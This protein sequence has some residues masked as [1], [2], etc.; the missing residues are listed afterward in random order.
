MNEA[1]KIIQL[2]DNLIE[3]NSLGQFYLNPEIAKQELWEGLKSGKHFSGLVLSCDAA[4]N[5]KVDINGIT[6]IM[7][8]N[9]VSIADDEEGLVHKALCQRKVGSTIKARVLKIEDDKIYVSRKLLIKGVRQ[10]YNNTITIGRIV[11][12]KVINIDENVGVFVDIGG[13]YVGII[14]KA[15]LENLFVTRLSDHVSINE[16]VEA[17]VIDVQ[18]NGSGDIAHLSLDRKSILPDFNS[19]AAEYNRGDVY[20]VKVKSV[21]QNGIYASL[22][23][24]L[25][26]ILD[27]DRNRYNQGDSL[28]VKITSIRQDKKRIAGVILG[29]L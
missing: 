24:H 4:G 21:H 28:R 27:F 8:R 16:T 17:V 20:V 10:I 25:D 19:L 14:P 23:K 11:K 12:G 9:E 13:D 6:C 18:K 7:E 5:L 15:Y 22:D 1:L 2:D 29:K 3:D 26:I